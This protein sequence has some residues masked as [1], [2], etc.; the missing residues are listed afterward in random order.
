M[1]ILN[2]KE[3][4]NAEDICNHIEKQLSIKLPEKGYLAG[5][6]V[7]SAY[8]ELTD[9][10][11]NSVYNDIDIFHKFPIEHFEKQY[12]KQKYTKKFDYKNNKKFV[13]EHIFFERQ[14]DGYREQN[15]RNENIFSIIKSRRLDQ[16]NFISI[17]PIKEKMNI[18]HLIESFDLNCTK[19]G[20]DLETNELYISQ[21]FKDFIKFKKLLLTDFGLPYHNPLRY[22]KKLFDLEIQSSFD[23]NVLEINNYAI[24]IHKL[25]GVK[26]EMPHNE[27]MF[28]SKA[29]P[30]FGN[31]YKE[32]Y[33]KHTKLHEYYYITV[34]SNYSNA[35]NDLFKLI[36]KKQ[37]K[38]LENDEFYN[39]ISEEMKIY[40]KNV[41]KEIR[42]LKYLKDTL[43]NNYN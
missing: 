13:Q 28:F 31:K 3:D 33:E 40:N 23:E 10:N 8:F 32:L 25:I 12:L 30:A 6:S 4:V 17:N 18:Q 9:Q 2:K 35:K 5:Q 41:F 39:N 19:I 20:I 42:L 11:F 29:T 15:I 22:A 43:S 24:S 38:I 37:E 7:A 1:L 21:D 27:H 14:N 36:P 16:F 26:K 34:D